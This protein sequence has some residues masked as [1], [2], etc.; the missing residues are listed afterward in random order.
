[1]TRLRRTVRI[2]HSAENLFELVSDI[3]RYPEFIRWFQSM[4][5]VPI[6][7]NMKETVVVGRAQVGFRGFSEFFSTQVTASNVAKTVQV[8]LIEGPLKHLQNEWQFREAD[9]ATDVDFFIDFEFRN[10]ILRTLAA[11]NFELA[12]QKILAAFVAEADRR[13]DKPQP[14]KLS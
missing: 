8:S 14:A 12:F 10:F 5:V 4:D 9:G 1:M 11:A 3:G 6:A 2:N 7:S 13:Y